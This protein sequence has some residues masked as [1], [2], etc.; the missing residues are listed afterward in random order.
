M[1]EFRKLAL[2]KLPDLPAAGVVRLAHTADNH[3]RLTANGST[4]RG[5]EFL[6]ALLS[7]MRKAA[8]RGCNAIVCAGDLVNSPENLPSVARQLLEVHRAAEDYGLPF[9]AIQGNHD[10]SKPSWIEVM[11]SDGNDELCSPGMHLLDNRTAYI[12]G[13]RVHGLPFLQPAELREVLQF[14]NLN[15]DVLVW[16]GSV[17][18]FAKFPTEGAITLSDFTASHQ[19]AVLLGDIH[20]C[21]YYQHDTAGGIGYPGATELCKR[22][23]PLTHGIVLLDFARTPTGWACIGTEHVPTWFRPVTALNIQREDEMPKI[24]A[25]LA[26]DWARTNEPRLVIAQYMSDL[27]D[28]RAR[29]QRAAGPESIVRAEGYKGATIPVTAQHLR[30]A[31]SPASYIPGAISDTG[32]A[33]LATQLAEDPDV[34]PSTLLNAYV[35]QFTAK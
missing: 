13:L 26:D 31:P 7:G 30:D 14:S 21:E 19:A 16:H 12:D 35:A 34:S 22:D 27:V 24:L 15:W 1:S 10:F 3:L 8:D 18:E 17:T 2:S 6:K 25:D 5:S 4:V 23:E 28:V 9:L 11:S 20:I 33:T 29:L 32:L